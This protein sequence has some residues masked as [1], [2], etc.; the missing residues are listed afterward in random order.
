MIRVRWNILGSGS[1]HEGIPVDSN[2]KTPEAD[3]YG[4]NA[5]F[6]ESHTLLAFSCKKILRSVVHEYTQCSNLYQNLFLKCNSTTKLLKRHHLKQRA[7]KLHGDLPCCYHRNKLNII[8]AF[9]KLPV[10]L[11][12]EVDSLDS[13]QIKVLNV[14]SISKWSS[15]WIVDGKTYIR[16]P[17]LVAIKLYHMNIQS[18]SR[19]KTRFVL[20]LLS[21]RCHKDHSFNCW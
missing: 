11:T 20:F 10:F 5:R 9:L 19:L 16:K 2:H 12:F 1:F 4:L 13:L 3:L 8:S 7:Q 21:R 14:N 6:Y 17:F 18:K 15:K